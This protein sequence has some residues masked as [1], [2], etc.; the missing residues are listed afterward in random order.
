[1]KRISSLFL[2]FL[3]F[4]Q[5]SLVLAKEESI[6]YSKSFEVQAPVKSSALSRF[7]KTKQLGPCEINFIKLVNGKIPEEVFTNSATNI[8]SKKFNERLYLDELMEIEEFKNVA[9]RMKYLEDYTRLIHKDEVYVRNLSKVVNQMY[10]EGLIKFDDLKLLFFNKQFTHARF[11]FSYSNQSMISSLEFDPVKLSLIDD[12]VGKSSHLGKTAREE[13]T[14]IFRQSN[15]TADQLQIAID[16]GF[17]LRQGRKDI[18]HL[19]NY[20]DF[21]DKYKKNPIGRA[22]LRVG[23]KNIERIFDPSEVPGKFNISK[24]W[25]PHKKFLTNTPENLNR[26]DAIDALFKNVDLDSDLKRQYKRYLTES[27]LSQENIEYL[28]KQGP[29]FLD[30]EM[31]LRKF[32]EYM[33]YM[34]YLPQY[35]LKGALKNFNKVFELGDDVRFFVPDQVLPPHK[36][37]L[38]QR[39]K[40]ANV[41]EKKYKTILQDLKQQQKD[42]LMKELD[43]MLKAKSQGVP[44]DEVRLA[45][46]KKELNST[47]LSEELVKRAKQM[48]KGEANVFSKLLNGCNSG[49]SARMQSAARKFKRFKLA[50]AV[51]GTPF[52]YLT[53]NWDKKEE[54]PFFWEKLGQEMAIGLFFTMVGNKIVTNTNQGFWAKYLEGYVKF[55]GLDLISAG[56][57]DAL[58]GAN[59]Y[60]R[61][62]QQIY[63][64]GEIPPSAVEEELKKLQESEDFEKDFQ[65]LKDFMDEKA[66]DANF[67][68]FLDKHIN[69]STYSSLDDDYHI[70]QED[71]ETEEAREVMM[72]LLAEK[73]YLM[74]MGD[75]PIFQTGNKGMDRWA[76]Y[77]GRNILFDMKGMAINLAIFEIMCRMPAG[78]AAIPHW[79]LILG[80]TLG[81]WML[82][83]SFTYNIR[84]E[85]INQ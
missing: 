75:W 39:K 30:D 37:F 60:V 77:R 66:K 20:M 54:D 11:S 72:E 44:I 73:I 65:A 4:F 25:K 24:F 59:S 45:Q 46:I 3:F 23:L 27:R 62:F 69:L 51:G 1:M 57:Y 9:T 53:K 18:E 52:F 47:E 80:L 82:S 40:V 76:F 12:F 21:L 32:K 22:K 2:S 50:L 81:D 19:R 15:I 70:T 63:K 29:K 79:G 49:G 48:A 78:A 28:S 35:R 26:R 85:A 71:L 31:A 74:N 14:Q 7:K 38:A 84:R 83:G 16:S 43:E 13:Y 68:N 6:R 8:W 17:T 61:Y 36:Q 10:R 58:F 64:G 33:I 56:S 42:D 41:E 67:K 5:S 55:S 34:D